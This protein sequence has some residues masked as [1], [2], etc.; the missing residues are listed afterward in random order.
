RWDVA[1]KDIVPTFVRGNS[2]EYFSENTGIF[3]GGKEWRWAD[4]RSFR[5]QSDRVDSGSYK[6]NTTDLYMKVDG[7]R[8]AQRYIYFSDI[9]GS[10]VITTYESVNPLWQG[11]YAT[12]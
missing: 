3:P 4:L 10:F 11:D 8:S 7:D 9:N 1:Q 2:L 12:V 5:L 6:R